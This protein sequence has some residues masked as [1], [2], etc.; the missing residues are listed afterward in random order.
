MMRSSNRIALILAI[1]ISFAILSGSTY[2]CYYSLSSADIISHGLKFE[3]FD[4]EFLDAASGSRLKVFRS[5]SFSII[6]A[7]CINPTE[8][9]PL[10]PFLTYPLDQGTPI[11]RC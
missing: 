10:F 3:T 4:Q 8:Q 7:L 9:I 2:F 5:S 11:L 6:S 1:A